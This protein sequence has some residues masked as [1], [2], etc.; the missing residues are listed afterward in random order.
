[1][2]RVVFIAVALVVAACGAPAP[3]APAS[4]FAASTPTVAPST[5]PSAVPTDLVVSG[6][7]GDRSVRRLDRDV[8]RRGGRRMPGRR[9]AVHE[10]PRAELE[11]GLRRERWKD[12]RGGPL[13]LPC[14]PG[15]GRSGP[16]LAGDGAG[17]RRT[18]LH[19]HRPL[20][21]GRRPK[22]QSRRSGRS[23]ATRWPGARADR[24]PG[25]RPASD[26]GQKNSSSSIGHAQRDLTPRPFRVG[27]HPLDDVPAV[28][29]VREG[30]EVLPVLDREEGSTR[31]YW[32]RVGSSRL[33]R[34]AVTGSP[35]GAARRGFEVPWLPERH[36]PTRWRCAG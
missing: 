1:M 27:R 14:R 17:C 20:A 18:D 9:G 2:K 24:R 31:A 4:S 30:D 16:V 5:Q 11:V 23:A 26:A 34:D 13:R 12:R 25:G 32:L 10:Q 15:L 19:G 28:V 8:L 21:E 3:S 36:T 29:L 22:A 7:E 6:T 33:L 35:R